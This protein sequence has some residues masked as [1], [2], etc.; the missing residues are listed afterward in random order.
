MVNILDENFVCIYIYLFKYN[1]NF[2]F[3]FGIFLNTNLLLR[4][5]IKLMIFK[6]SISKHFFF[7]II[8]ILFKKQG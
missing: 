6:D 7:Q 4:M 2:N 5:N 3:N 8:L 1:I